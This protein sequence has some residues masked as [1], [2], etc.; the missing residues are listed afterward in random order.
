[1]LSQDPKSESLSDWCL[2]SMSSSNLAI[3]KTKLN[4][5][6]SWVQLG[7]LDDKLHYFGQNTEAKVNKNIV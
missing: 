6:S 3:R 4:F 7:Q 2:H 5:S 1:M